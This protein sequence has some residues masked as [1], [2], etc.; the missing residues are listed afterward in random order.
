[1][2]SADRRRGWILVAA[3]FLLLAVIV[4]GPL[5]G[6]W[7]VP[8]PLHRTG[9]VLRWVG[10]A[11]IVVGALRL[12][13]GV[14]V[15]PV[16]SRAAVLRTDGLYRFVRHPIYSGVL[17]LAAGITATS[18]SVAAA[19]AL[20]ALIVLLNTKARF[21]ERLLLRRFPGYAVYAGR[22]PRFVPSLR[23]R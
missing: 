18:G 20:G 21:E 11:A 15:H 19:A 9:T 17:L 3:Q 1:V 23:R 10:G 22:T 12:G 7:S 13:R 4:I 8:G 6:G 5:D 2:G 16:P 14:S